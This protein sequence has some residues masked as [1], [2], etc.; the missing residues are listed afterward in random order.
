MPIFGVMKTMKVMRMN[1]VV[2][3]ILII[4]KVIEK[5]L[6][7]RNEIVILVNNVYS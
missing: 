6:R 4:L 1:K 2:I 7:F 5:K 3:R